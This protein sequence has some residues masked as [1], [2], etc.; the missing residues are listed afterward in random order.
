MPITLEIDH[1]KL[2]GANVTLNMKSALAC[3]QIR[4]N[5]QVIKRGSRSYVVTGTSGLPVFIRL[6]GRLVDPIPKVLVDDEEVNLVP[7]LKWYQYVWAGLPI[8]LV[9]AGGALGG[10]IGFVTARINAGLMRSN[11]GIATRYLAVGGASAASFAAYF[12]VAYM[13]RTLVR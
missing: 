11:M 5:D 6:Q 8:L 10:L 2:S 9:G 13:L 4:Q 7:P 12:I 3:P 1:A